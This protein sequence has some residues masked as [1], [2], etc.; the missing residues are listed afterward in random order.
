MATLLEIA[1]AANVSKTT[2]SRAL[3]CDP[4]LSITSET[5]TKILDAAKNLGY[6]VKEERRIHKNRTIAVIHKDD[7]FETLWTPYVVFTGRKKSAHI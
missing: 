4:T 7:H 1:Q 3:R 5:R 2:V 6:T